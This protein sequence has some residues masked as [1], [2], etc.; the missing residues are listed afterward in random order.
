MTQTTQPP[1]QT[2]PPGKPAQGL[3]GLHKMSAT[4][5]VAL[6]EYRSIN[7]PAVASLVMGVAS[8][9][10]LIHPLLYVLPAGAVALGLIG[11][12][13]VA[14]SNGTQGGAVL[15][16]LGIVLGL[17]LGGWALAA[18]ITRS[19]RIGGHREEI[20]RTIGQFGDRLA[21]ADYDAAYG[22][23]SNNLRREISL[24]SFRNEMMAEAARLGGF[25]GAA[26]NQLARVTED[27]DGTITAE[28][29]IVVQ[30]PGPEPLRQG[31]RLVREVEGWRIADFESWFAR[32][33]FSGRRRGA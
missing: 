21:A 30:T 25:R 7:V 24:E 29:M 11:M 5:G 13:Q 4:A 20:A 18:D 3:A 2:P 16:G 8:W 26:T 28:A 10:S 19:N 14:R 6:G 22:F 9:M 33:A 15:A 17:A 31:L 27:A 1:T 23:L 12:Y 32:D